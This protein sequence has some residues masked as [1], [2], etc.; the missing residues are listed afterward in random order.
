MEPDYHWWR[1]KLWK[2]YPI[3]TAKPSPT[4]ALQID[5]SLPSPIDAVPIVLKTAPFSLSDKY[6]F[7][8]S[9]ISVPRKTLLVTT[10]YI[11]TRFGI[12]AR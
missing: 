5:T 10:D 3:D 2:K 1:R 7:R 6:P 4:A 9:S 12:S 11:H 8:L